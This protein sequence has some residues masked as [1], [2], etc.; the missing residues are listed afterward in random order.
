MTELLERLRALGSG[1]L[2]QDVLALV[3][4]AALEMTR[5]DR[6]FIMLAA[7]DGR[8]EFRMGRGPAG[9]ALNDTTLR[10]A[11]RCQTRSS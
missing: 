11:G 10:P 9:H 8:L 1:R 7:G 2:V 5:A 4:D 3:L 6:G